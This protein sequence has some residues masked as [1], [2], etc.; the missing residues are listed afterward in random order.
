MN[1]DDVILKKLTKSENFHLPEGYEQRLNATLGGLPEFAGRRPASRTGRWVAVAAAVALALFIILPNTSA[2]V[3]HAMENLP[4]IGPL[5]RVITFRDY[6][7]DDEHST[8]DVQVPQIE[9]ESNAA[10]LINQD[11]DAYA[12]TLIEQFKAKK[13]EIGKGYLGLDI[14]YQVVTDTDDWFTLRLTVV[15]T[16]ASGYEYNVYYNV[17]KMTGENVTLGD[18]FQ[19]GTEWAAVIDAEILRQMDEQMATEE[20]VMYFPEEF[21]GV[22]DEQDYYWNDAGELMIAF[23]EYEVAPGM[24]GTPE[25]TIPSELISDLMK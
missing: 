18:L 11:V 16:Q 4:V 15:E 2:A 20:G 23:D 21:T 1:P 7:Y 6:K 10:S 5:V 13:E 22:T 14:S 8:A 12:S 19:E 25:F 24:M 9:D 3:A 17:D